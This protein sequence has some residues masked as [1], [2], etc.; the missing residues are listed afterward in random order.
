MGLVYMVI[1]MICLNFFMLITKRMKTLNDK[2]TVI[3]S[4]LIRG[5]FQAVL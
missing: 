1:A 4:M 5:M 3:E 2:F